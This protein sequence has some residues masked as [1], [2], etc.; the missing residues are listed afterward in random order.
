[1]T[2]PSEVNQK[3]KFHDITF[4]RNLNYDTGGFIYKT[5]KQTHRHRKQTYGYQRGERGR[6]KLRVWD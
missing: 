4:M 1:M 2:I 6:D 3:D 5:K